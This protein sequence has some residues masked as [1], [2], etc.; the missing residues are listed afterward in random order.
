[1]FFEGAPQ[2]GSEITGILA[3]AD[4]DLRAERHRSRDFWQDHEPVS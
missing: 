3:F 2:R 1:M 4:R